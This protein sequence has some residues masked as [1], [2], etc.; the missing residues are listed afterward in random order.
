LRNTFVKRSNRL[1]ILVGV[2]LA[3]LAFVLVVILLN[4][5]QETVAP[6]E[7]TTVTVLVATQ[8]IE[9]GDPVTPDL[10]ETQEVEPGAAVATRLADPSQLRGQPALFRV[11]A[12]S[13]VTQ[14]LIGVVLPGEVPLGEQ[15]Q[16]GEKAIAIQ[17]ERVT[18]LDFL[19]RPGD[20]IDIVTA[21]Q[22]TVL[23]ETVDS[24]QAEEGVPV[25]FETVPGLEDVRTV[26]TVLQ[27]KRVLYVSATRSRATTP[28]PAEGEEPPAQPPAEQVIENVII[29]F[30]GTDQ[31]AEVIKFAQRDLNELGALTVVIRHADDEEDEPTTGIT[32]DILVEQY[33]VPIP[34]IVTDLQPTP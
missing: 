3:V 29:V 9:I 15:L 20:I 24:A 8:D 33:G 19:V 11:P 22:I 27:N 34:G 30:A 28:E 2:L 31:D 5:Q 10:V 25:R 26:K 18:G 32:I 17:V 14:E 1:V 23:Q 7:P 12:G 4:Q 13:Q 16:P 6:T 21:Q